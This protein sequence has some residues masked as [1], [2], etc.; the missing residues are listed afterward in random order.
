MNDI[1]KLKKNA[2]RLSKEKGIQ[3]SAA[4]DIIA[5]T[6]GFATWSQLHNAVMKSKK[7]DAK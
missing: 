7:H 2:K 6:V 5:R 3:H 4:L 1:A